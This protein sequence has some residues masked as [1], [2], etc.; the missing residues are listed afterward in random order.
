MAPYLTVALPRRPAERHDVR[1]RA[2]GGVLCEDFEESVARAVVQKVVFSRHQ[3][4]DLKYDP[5]DL[6]DAVTES[7]T[8]ADGFFLSFGGDGGLARAAGGRGRAAGV[9][10]PDDR[11]PKPSSGR[12]PEPQRSRKRNDR[13]IR[14]PSNGATK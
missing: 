3:T 6:S 5:V 14:R 1:F 11:R 7:R 13:G 4:F 8:H 12:T 10:P 2:V 9:E